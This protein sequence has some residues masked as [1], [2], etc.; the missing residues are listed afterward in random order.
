MERRY[1]SEEEFDNLNWQEQMKYK[2]CAL[3]GHF[4]YTK[5][6]ECTHKPW[7]SES[8]YSERLKK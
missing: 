6:G 2:W 7:L 3:C 1:I 8:A 5:K 4:Y